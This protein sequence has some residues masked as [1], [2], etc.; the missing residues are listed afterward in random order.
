M[1]SNMLETLTLE[2][3][4]H[5]E[6]SGSADNVEMVSPWLKIFLMSDSNRDLL[7]A[8][9]VER[10]IREIAAITGFEWKYLINEFAPD[11]SKWLQ[12]NLNP[13][14]SNKV[15]CKDWTEPCRT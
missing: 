5:V 6:F 4:E 11:V 3:L 9:K 2:T 8:V 1:S 13:S 15:E 12:I 14:I 10:H 7:T